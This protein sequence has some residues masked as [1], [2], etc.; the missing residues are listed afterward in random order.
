MRAMSHCR[1]RSVARTP[2]TA[3]R[4]SGFTL[5]ELLVVMA[6]IAALAAMLL[7]AVQNAREAARRTECLNNMKQIGLGILQY[8]DAHRAFP[9]G[10][11]SANAPVL[12]PR[13]RSLHRSRAR[14]F[15][16]HCCR[17]WTSRTS[18]IACSRILPEASWECRIRAIPTARRWMAFSSNPTSARQQIC[19]GLRTWMVR[20]DGLNS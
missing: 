10:A 19:P 3:N 18:S 4:R 14:H 8:H 9:I 12:A 16:C 1:R 13:H 20:M 7:P 5:V 17:G 2:I 15:S 6:I 11:V